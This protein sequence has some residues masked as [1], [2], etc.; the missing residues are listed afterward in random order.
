MN[1]QPTPKFQFSN[2]VVVD[3][4]LIGCIVKT[5]GASINRGVH[6]EVYVRSYNRI[7]EY[8]EKD[9]KHFIYDKE[10]EEEE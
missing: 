8:D 9:I 10:L 5:W 4:K 3:E 2:V 6:Y 7:E 1:N